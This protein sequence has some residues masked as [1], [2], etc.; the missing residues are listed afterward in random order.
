MAWLSHGADTAERTRLWLETAPPNSVILADWHWY[1]P[2]NYLQAVEG[3]RGDV[4]V[5]FVFPRTD[6]CAQDW[7][8]QIELYLS[9]GRPVIATHYDESAFADLPPPQAHHDLLLYPQAGETTAVPDSWAAQT[10]DFGGAL[11]LL[12]F[13]YTQ[14]SGE[15][16]ETLV[17]DVAWTAV[18]PINLSLKLFGPP[19]Q[20][21]AQD[22][23]LLRPQADG[24][25]LSRF[26]LTPRLG[27][28][29]GEYTVLVTATAADGTP[30][31]VAD[32][33]TAVQIGTID[34]TGS[35]WRP[36]TANRDY[37]GSVRAIW[38][39]EPQII[40]HDWDNAWPESPRLYVHWRGS[41][42]RY[43]TDSFDSS[44]GEVTVDGRLFVNPQDTMYVPFAEGIVWT[45]N[46]PAL[47]SQPTEPN[48]VV[49]TSQ[50]FRATR[51]IERDIGVAIRLIG[52]EADLFTWAWVNGD[53]DNDIPA[54]GAI[55]TLK[56]L[57]GSEIAHPRRLTIS[58]E[59]EPGQEMGGFLRLYD[60]F[61]NRPLP[62]LDE[63]YGEA[64]R[65][66]VTFDNGNVIDE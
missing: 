37:G 39:R 4:L 47:A 66:W 61:T 21:Y 18:E 53:E 26:R 40:G 16:G 22:D 46:R 7:V 59:A 15:L 30:L 6:D 23:Q 9:D 8:N 58:P 27:A 52:Y 64:N 42:G 25:T 12:A 54:L 14:S 2:L 29:R 51:P 10:A 13:D 34:L 1:T 56:W 35:R 57:A 62:I 5:E 41:D 11:Q 33:N 43:W 60:V 19:W 38:S 44:V 32:G 50:S 20:A 55:P 65:P 48:G 24:A 3:R 28:P 31:S 36:Y 17:V 45:G 49:R 63:R